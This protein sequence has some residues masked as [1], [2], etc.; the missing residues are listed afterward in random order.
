M[1][2]M[3]DDLSVEYPRIK[4][5]RANVVENEPKSIVAMRESSIKKKTLNRNMPK[6]KKR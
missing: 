2:K 3:C 6:V 1:R 4:E 5:M